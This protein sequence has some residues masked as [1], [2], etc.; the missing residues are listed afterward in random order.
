MGSICLRLIVIAQCCYFRRRP[1]L[2]GL[3]LGANIELFIF[4]DLLLAVQSYV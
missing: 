2:L 4:N 1:R 3:R